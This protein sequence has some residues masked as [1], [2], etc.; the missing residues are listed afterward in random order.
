MLNAI[1]YK[2]NNHY[3]TFKI[4][5]IRYVRKAIII[6]WDFM[7]TKNEIHGFD[8]DAMMHDADIISWKC[9]IDF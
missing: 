4:F 8:R 2:E 3:N 5:D 7:G 6:R 9:L 1:I